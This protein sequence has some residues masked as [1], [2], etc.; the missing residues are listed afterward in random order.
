MCNPAHVMN[1]SLSNKWVISETCENSSE[2]QWGLSQGCANNLSHSKTLTF[3]LT[4]S[5]TV[6]LPHTIKCT[7][8]QGC[9]VLCVLPPLTQLMMS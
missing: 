4:C 3:H 1:T 2:N 6:P 8:T 5:C 9:P 7:Q